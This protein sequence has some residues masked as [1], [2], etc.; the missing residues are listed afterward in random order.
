MFTGVTPK[1]KPG[2]GLLEL[3]GGATKD[4]ITLKIEPDQIEPGVRFPVTVA[5]AAELSP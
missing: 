4:T 3:K 5:P 2:T 1:C